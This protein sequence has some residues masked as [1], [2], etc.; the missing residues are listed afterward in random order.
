MIVLV[1][2]RALSLRTCV[3]RASVRCRVGNEK[4][5]VVIVYGVKVQR[6]MRK[7][8]R[9]WVLCVKRARALIPALV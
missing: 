5:E 1:S 8:C 7:V 2:E 3:V 6:L 9:Q 4:V